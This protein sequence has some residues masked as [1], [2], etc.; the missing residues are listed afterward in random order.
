[1]HC[2]F[3]L[4]LHYSVSSML[5]PVPAFAVRR[6]FP[7]SALL[8]WLYQGMFP[9][10]ACCSGSIRACSPALHCCPSSISPVV[11]CVVLGAKSGFVLGNFLLAAL[12]ETQFIISREKRKKKRFHDWCDPR[13]SWFK[14]TWKKT[15]S[16]DFKA[17]WRVGDAV[18]SRENAGWKTSKSGHPCPCQSC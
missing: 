15:K 6:M 12:T 13:H 18:V 1:M 9:S 17:P 11:P 14:M 3:R 7:S 16:A 8:P 5:C 10:S 2:P 4:G